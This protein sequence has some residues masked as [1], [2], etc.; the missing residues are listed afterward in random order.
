MCVCVCV[1]ACMR[2][3]V[4]VTHLPS[5]GCFQALMPLGA[6]IGAPLAAWLVD[7]AG[8][9]NALLYCSVPFATGWLITVLSYIPDEATPVRVLLFAGR[10]IVGI[11]VGSASLC[12]PVSFSLCENDKEDYDN[13]V[14][15]V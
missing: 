8:R 7:Y 5:V 15:W 13:C 11:G 2:V 4:G 14:W 3:C 10:F 6:L 9:K 12:V 1:R